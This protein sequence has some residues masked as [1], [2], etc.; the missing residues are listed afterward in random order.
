MVPYEIVVPVFHPFRHE[1]R[2]NL[3]PP[4]PSS[5][6]RK[7]SSTRARYT[8]SL[9]HHRD[10]G[11]CRV[12]WAPVCIFPSGNLKFAPRETGLSRNYATRTGD[13]G[14]HRAKLRWIN[15]VRD[16]RSFD[17]S[18]LTISSAMKTKTTPRDDREGWNRRGQLESRSGSGARSLR[19]W[20][21]QLP[22]QMVV[23]LLRRENERGSPRN[24][25]KIS[26]VFRSFD[27]DSE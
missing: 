12:P 3:S 19:W 27:R 18:N 7:C 2:V 15:A 25:A 8:F 16:V 23:H 1:A 6:N 10:P 22:R 9:L 26:F 24:P 17:L 4:S 20:V 14:Y 11:P 5:W 13:T 21:V